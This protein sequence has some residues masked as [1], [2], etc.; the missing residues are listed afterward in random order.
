[1]GP[2]AITSVC[3]MLSFKLAF[4][5]SSFTVIKRLF[6]FSSLY[7]IRVVSCAYVKFWTFLLAILIPACDSSSPAIHMILYSAYNLNRVTI[8]SLVVLLSQFWTAALTKAVTHA[9]GPTRMLTNH[10]LC[11]ANSTTNQ[12][13]R[14]TGP[15]PSS[16]KWLIRILPMQ[17]P[18]P[19]N[20]C[21]YF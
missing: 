10:H 17:K 8:Y 7:A 11:C 12:T 20:L 14:T 6:S 1:M 5:I 2:D 4:S 13:I 21:R 15:S 18:K 16:W 19:V 3:W 9:Y